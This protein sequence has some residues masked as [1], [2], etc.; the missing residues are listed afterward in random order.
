MC[1]D[2]DTWGG[3]HAILW[4]PIRSPIAFVRCSDGNAAAKKEP[5]T[6]PEE[7]TV[8]GTGT[9]EHAH[10]SGSVFGAPGGM[11][12]GSVSSRSTYSH[13]YKVQT[14]TK[15]YELDCGK[16][17]VFQGF[18]STEPECL[19]DGKPI[20]VGDV[21]HFRINNDSAYIRQLNPDGTQ[22]EEKLRILSEDEAPK[23]NPSAPAPQVQQ[24]AVPNTTKLSIP[25]TPAGADIEVDG[26]FVG[27]TPSMIEVSPG[28]HTVT[29][30][31]SGYK[32]W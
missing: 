12:N 11:T 15:I 32:S 23:Q 26:G 16:K 4:A 19:V 21:I 17:A 27:N 14:A 24:V 13:T 3:S 22:S 25:S 7:G 31:K 1:C 29:V 8:V 9:T 18:H 28:D 2:V 6:Y 30:S 10:T 20:K 5:K